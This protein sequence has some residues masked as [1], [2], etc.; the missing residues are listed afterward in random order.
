[1]QITVISENG[2]GIDRF[3]SVKNI[4]FFWDNKKIFLTYWKTVFWVTEH[5]C[6]KWT[7]WKNAFFWPKNAFFW[8]KWQFDHLLSIAQRWCQGPFFWEVFLHQFL[9]RKNHKVS[10]F[11][12]KFL[13][14]FSFLWPNNTKMKKIH[15]EWY[16]RYLIYSPLTE[17]GLWKLTK[18]GTIGNFFFAIG[19][20]RMLW[21]DIKMWKSNDLPMPN[22]PHFW[23]FVVIPSRQNRPKG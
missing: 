13:S 4:N 11:C 5:F 22:V 6:I 19:P 20:I 3:N 15:P 16:G 2:R 8:R 21:G 10:H 23:W 18:E 9:K 7:F 12:W 14:F 1:M 17:S